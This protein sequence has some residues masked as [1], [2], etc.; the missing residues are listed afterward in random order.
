MNNTKKFCGICSKSLESWD[1]NICVDCRKKK[2]VD[3]E[4]KNVQVGLKA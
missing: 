2:F 4:K 1:A 3:M